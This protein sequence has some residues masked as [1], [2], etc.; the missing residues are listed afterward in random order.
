VRADIL[1]RLGNPLKLRSG[2]RT[3]EYQTKPG[4]RIA[5]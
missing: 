3:A 2:A 4:Q 1:S 5:F